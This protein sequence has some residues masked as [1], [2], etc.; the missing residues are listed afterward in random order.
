MASPERTTTFM[1][2]SRIL[3]SG[4]V[5]SAA[6]SL[7]ADAGTL[8][9][10]PIPAS[11]SDAQAGIDG[12]RNY[13]NAVAAGNARERAVNGVAFAPLSGADDVTTSNGV[14]VSAA[15]GTLANGGGKSESI[16]ADGAVARLFSGMIF[17]DG[18]ADNSEQYVVLDPESLTAGKTY[19]LRV[20]IGNATGE[21]RQVNLSFA[22]DGKPAVNTDFFNEDDATTSAGG[23]A[24]PNQVYYINYRFTWDGVST[25]GFTATQR[26]GSTPFVLFALTNHEVGGEADAPPAGAITQVEPEPIAA[27][28]PRNL[29][30]STTDYVDDIGVTSDVFYSSD[31]LRRHGR[32]VTVGSYGRCWQPSDVGDDWEPYTRGRWVYS[33]DDGWVWD[34]DE[35]FGWATYHY[36]RWFR[37]EDSGWY[38]VPGKVWGPGWVSWRHGHSHIGWAPL[39]PAALVVAGIGISAWADHRWGM[40]P[41]SYNFVNAR[42]FGAPSMS[43]VL[44]PRQQNAVIMANTNNV[45]N[46]ARTRNGF[47]NGGPNFNAVNNALVRGGNSAIPTVNV[48]RRPTSRPVTPEGRFSS[49]SGGVLAVAAPTVTRTKKP[50]SLPPVAATIAKPKFDRGW[51]GIAD[52]NRATALQAKIASELPTSTAKTAPARLPGTIPS[53]STTP[54][55]TRNGL[56]PFRN[57]D[58]GSNAVVI[59]GQPVV[60]RLVNPLTP[61]APTNPG[62]TS[63]NLP[64]R[65]ALSTNGKGKRNELPTVPNVTPIKPGQPANPVAVTPPTPGSIVA[66]TPG[67]G[68]RGD[69]PAGGLVKPGAPVSPAVVPVTPGQVP[70]TVVVPGTKQGQRVIPGSVTP[71]VSVPPATSPTSPTSPKPETARSKN[72]QRD[73]VPATPSVV[74]KPGAPDAPKSTPDRVT[75]APVVTPANPVVTPKDLP[76]PGR[77]S[78]PSAPKEP[79]AIVKPVVQPPAPVIKPTA[80]SD[81]VRVRRKVEPSAPVPAPRPAQTPAPNSAPEAPRV[82]RQMPAPP[83]PQTAPVPRQV[84]RPAPVQI[85]K[86][87]PQPIAQPRP[88]PVQLPKAAPQP[89]VQPRPAPVQPPRPAPQPVQPPRPAPQPVAQPKPA[90]VLPRPVPA[91]VALPRPAVP[92]PAAPAPSRGGPK[93]TPTPGPR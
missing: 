25:P 84:E 35:D 74:V 73:G 39:P 29:K 60:P 64:G 30:A 70:N 5:L 78:R 6:L 22:G 81:P 40:G 61:G 38:W 9:Y 92:V 45:T 21:N 65:S 85:P 49:L 16:Q 83:A 13:T 86:V 10:V 69:R 26:F 47:F 76:R 1:M 75:P 54:S 66:P 57:K 31:T 2:N 68:K 62:A 91:P 51:K 17:N 56:K 28:P 52:P 42:D 19:D 88:A 12:G 48:D 82:K 11:G 59:P 41:R 37:E 24:D 63:P 46:I 58:A 67:K 80:P 53:A 23:F 14:T 34:S 27:P 8:F 71:P 3:L 90:P 18:A 43:R 33:R 44:I 36:G 72:R 20:Y 77:V 7:Q 55:Q 15:T 4:M 50:T 87:A 89:V 79:D 93:P 32:W